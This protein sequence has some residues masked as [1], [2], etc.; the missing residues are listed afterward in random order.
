[1]AASEQLPE[2]PLSD[3]GMAAMLAGESN[4]ADK[5]SFHIRISTRGTFE[6]RAIDKEQRDLTLRGMR[7][8]DSKQSSMLCLL[9][10]ET[11]VPT[12]HPIRSIKKLV[13]IALKD[14]SP[15]LDAMYA[16][17]GRPSIPPERLL[18]ATLLMA[19]YSLRS[20]RL[21]CEQLNYNLLF[22][23]FLDMDMAEPCFDASTFSK[24]RLRLIEADIAKQFFGRVVEQ[25]RQ[26]RLMS[27][28]HFTVDGTLIEAWA[29]LKSFKK[30]DA[31]KDAPPPDDPGNPTVDFRGEKR[32]N[33]THES[34]TDPEARLARK[35]NGT[36]SKLS[37]SA[38]S[39][40]ENRNGLLVDFRVGLATGTAERTVALEMVDQE[41]TGERRITLA[42]DR[43]YDTSDF[44]QACR[45][46]NISPHIAQN[47]SNR[48]SALDGRTTRHAGYAISQRFRKRVEEIFGW[49]KTIGG[50]RRTRFRGTVR[51]Q[52]AAYFVG[53]AY[54]LLRMATLLAT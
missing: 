8:A 5:S 14:L 16:S 50:F 44:V 49:M 23:W 15:A 31:P 20:E 37:F 19:F 40:M 30:K 26:A 22:R 10:P 51:T 42:G 45:I 21:F 41:L 12:E 25:A 6:L 11:A 2:P 39:L 13:D 48:R 7:G 27:H 47:T 29:S 46:R 53:A 43:G 1:M 9:S 32:S 33:D 4:T 54:N 38:H 18:K 28:E 3:C 36:T 24:N 34:S 17:T 52:L 35:S